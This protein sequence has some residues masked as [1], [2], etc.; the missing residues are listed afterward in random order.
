MIEERTTHLKE[1]LD[2]YAELARL[3]APRRAHVAWS[4]V[5]GPAREAHPRVSA[6]SVAGT[7]Y[8]DRRQIAQVV[9]N[10]IE[11]AAE[12]SSPPAEIE[13]DV[14]P[15]DCGATLFVRDRGP[16]MSAEVLKNA[17][18]PFYSTKE[19]GTGLGWRFAAR[20][21]M[22]TAGDS[23]SRTARG[24][25]RGRV[26]PPR[27]GP[28]EGNPLAPDHRRARDAEGARGDESLT[29]SARAS[30]RAR[31]CHHAAASPSLHESECS[32]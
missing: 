23:R 9:E 22:R 12:A 3:P 15:A 28:P 1:F 2:G 11:N 18:L 7:G 26:L 19:R 29:G 10:L 32:A 8:F 4:E 14:E 6:R 30:L 27:L 13:L 20:S 21:S 24:R 17:L 25:P 16:G 5:L 31:R